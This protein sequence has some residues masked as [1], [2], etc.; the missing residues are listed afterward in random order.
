[1]SLVCDFGPATSC[2]DPGV[3]F[4]DAEICAG[5]DL[6]LCRGSP[7]AGRFRGL[8]VA[9]GRAFM[10]SPHWLGLDGLGALVLLLVAWVS[11]LA[12]LF[13]WGYLEHRAPEKNRRRIYYTNFNLFVFALLAVPAI[14]EP[15]LEWIAVELTALFSVLLVAYNNTHEAL[16]AAWKYIALMFMGAAIALLGFLILYWAP[17]AGGVVTTV[18]MACARRSTNAAGAGHGRV[19]I[20]PCRVRHKSWYCADPYVAA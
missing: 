1:M 6:A 18:G 2:G 12:A 16:E 17:P 13:S 3:V 9:A 20:D 4:S 15:N 11:A 5:G 10:V 19:P 7:L 8:E 14:R